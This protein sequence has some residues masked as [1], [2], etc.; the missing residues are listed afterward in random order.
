MATLTKWQEAIFQDGLFKL[1]Q[2][3]SIN[4]SPVNT[5]SIP[6]LT[7]LKP[8]GEQYL[9]LPKKSNLAPPAIAHS[10]YMDIQK[11]HFSSEKKTPCAITVTRSVFEA[12][13]ELYFVK[14]TDSKT[15]EEQLTKSFLALEKI[16]TEDKEKFTEIQTVLDENLKELQTIPSLSEDE[17]LSKLNS[18]DESSERFA[19]R[20][21]AGFRNISPDI[22]S[23]IVGHPRIKQ[24]CVIPLLMLRKDKSKEKTEQTLNAI[25]N[26]LIQV[27]NEAHKEQ[28]AR[29]KENQ[30]AAYNAL[31]TPKK[32]V[33]KLVALF[34]RLCTTIKKTARRIYNSIRSH[35]GFTR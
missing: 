24:D 15:Y 9:D 5:P 11:S 2:G 6:S 32:I 28:L 14:I 12:I 19:R 29:E 13:K 22:Q 3:I 33:L 10:L 8:M 7:T 18:D 20:L 21:A 30:R 25:D 4:M 31:P 34:N 16:E 27:H 26:S 17:I 1:S 35:R 23:K